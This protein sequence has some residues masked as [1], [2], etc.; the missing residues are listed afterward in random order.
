M[1]DALLPVIVTMYV[2]TAAALVV[3]TLSVDEPGGLTGLAVKRVD[4]LPVEGET[5]ALNVTELASVLTPRDSAPVGAWTL[6][7]KLVDWP[8]VTVCD[9]GVA[10]SR[11]SPAIGPAI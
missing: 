11:K 1:T 3:V 10:E 7:P 2:P 9:E 8:A 6:I 4:M 5:V